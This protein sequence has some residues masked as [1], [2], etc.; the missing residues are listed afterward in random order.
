[1]HLCNW[2]WLKWFSIFDTSD[3]GSNNKKS[4]KGHKKSCVPLMIRQLPQVI[5]K[6]MQGNKCILAW[7]QGQYI[8]M[9]CKVMLQWNASRTRTRIN[10]ETEAMCCQFISDLTLLMHRIFQTVFFCRV[11]Q[12]PIT[13]SGYKRPS[14]VCWCLHDR[15]RFEGSLMTCNFRT[16]SRLQL[17]LWLSS[18]DLRSQVSAN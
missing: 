15:W 11:K 10:R 9:L 1:M 16:C 14:A 8:S 12:S 13:T 5:P 6:T 3:N 2:Y 7:Y 4:H 17:L 18:R